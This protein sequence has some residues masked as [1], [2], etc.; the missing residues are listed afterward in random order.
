VALGDVLI[1]AQ[2]DL[3]SGSMR[4]VEIAQKLGKKIYVFPHRI[5]DSLGTNQ[6]LK[7]GL[8]TPIYDIDLFADMF[9]KITQED[10]EILEFCKINSDFD[11]IYENF[12]DKIYEYELAGKIEIK[13]L[14]VIVL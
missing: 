1:V 12:G 11:M 6:L 7:D 13:N 2:A 9:G 8:A 5:G 3:N 4:S 14:K 10:D